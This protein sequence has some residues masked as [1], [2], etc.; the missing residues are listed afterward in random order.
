MR[1]FRSPFGL[2]LRAIKSNQNRMRY[3]GFNTRPYLMAAFVISGIYAGLAGSLMAAV[4]PLA[5]A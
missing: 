3:T 1:I 2:M 4:D 5:R